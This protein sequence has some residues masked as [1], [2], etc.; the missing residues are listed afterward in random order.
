VADTDSRLVAPALSPVEPS[1]DGL[2]VHEG[3]WELSLGP[4]R[5]MIGR[6]TGV[7][8]TD[9]LDLRELATI[10]SRLEGYVESER[11]E[12]RVGDT[13]EGAET[14]V[15]WIVRLCKTGKQRLRRLL[16]LSADDSSNNWGADANDKRQPGTHSVETVYALSRVFRAALEARR[17][18]LDEDAT[19]TVRSHR[20]Q[21][22]AVGLQGPQSKR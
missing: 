10:T 13:R 4:Y 22:W 20:V 16:S 6:V 9:D 11:R 17:E 12:D 1:L 2:T 7:D 15:H 8:P 3:R 18:A 14:T 5:T 19:G 21:P